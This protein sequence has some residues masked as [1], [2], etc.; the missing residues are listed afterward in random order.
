VSREADGGNRQGKGRER[1]RTPYE[2]GKER[3]GGRKIEGHSDHEKQGG[4]AIYPLNF[5]GQLAQV[6]A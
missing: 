6:S 5:S 2:Q 4:H 1:I 3:N